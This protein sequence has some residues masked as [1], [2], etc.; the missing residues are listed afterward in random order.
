MN[1]E[2]AT[3]EKLI[4]RGSKMV[5]AVATCDRTKLS[6]DAW[7]QRA[8]PG[9]GREEVLIQSEEAMTVKPSIPW[10]V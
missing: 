1:S 6:R 4:L 3:F 10:L 5:N 8:F 2:Y 7:T 9:Q